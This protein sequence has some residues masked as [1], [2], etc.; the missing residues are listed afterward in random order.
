MGAKG[1]WRHVQGTAVV[2]IPYIVTNGI[3]V[4]SDRKTAATEDQIEAKEAKIIEFEKR[5]Y[6]AC[7]ILL[8]TTS[9][10]LTSTIKDLPTA[11]DMWKVV[12]DDATSKSTL[13][14]LDAEDQLSSIKLADNNDPGAHLGEL[15]NHFQ[16]MLQCQ[17]NRIKTGSTMSDTQFNIII[18]S[19]LP[20][21]YQPTLQ[22]ITTSERANKLSGSQLTTIKADDLIAFIIEEAQHQVKLTMSTQKLL[23]QPSQ[24]ALKHRHLKGKARRNPNISQISPAKTAKDPAMENLIATPRE[25]AKKSKD[26]SRNKKPKRKKLRRL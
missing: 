15:Q 10:R 22:T 21:S 17:D 16:L 19:S 23:N 3:P 20:E 25:V 7:H 5:E 2:P 24:R 18:M 13:Y 8:S 26:Q 6:L 9:T 11:E 12:K 4:L 1:L 14:L